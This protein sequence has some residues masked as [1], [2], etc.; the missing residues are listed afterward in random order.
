MFS[1][2]REKDGEKRARERER[3]WGVVIWVVVAS[4]EKKE[5]NVKK[6]KK[7]KP[8]KRMTRRRRN[9][10]RLLP[11]KMNSFHT[12]DQMI[13]LCLNFS[14][15]Q[16]LND[17][18]ELLIDLIERIHWNETHGSIAL[19]FIKDFVQKSVIIQMNTLETCLCISW[20]LW[21]NLS[22]KEKM[23]ISS[24]SFENRF[25]P[26]PVSSLRTKIIIPKLTDVK[27]KWSVGMKY[28]SLKEIN[29]FFSP[30]GSSPSIECILINNDIWLNWIVI[31]YWREFSFESVT[32]LLI[33]N[34]ENFSEK[35]SG[36][37]SFPSSHNYLR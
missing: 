11:L 3:E 33:V 10:H 20:N 36:G 17:G 23:I 18:W 15:N 4:T 1:R 21:T 12:S 6:K 37:F 2:E 34:F 35:T 28:S 13:R 19:M 16:L 22:T 14:E 5:Q 8:Q 26:R 32:S 9:Q 31:E 29:A 27:K 25:S 7:R 30:Q 24:T